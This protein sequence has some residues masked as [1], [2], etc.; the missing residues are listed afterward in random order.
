MHW[1]IHFRVNKTASSSTSTIK[2]HAET[3]REACMEVLNSYRAA[4]ILSYQ[5][6]DDPAEAF[7]PA[8]IGAACYPVDPNAFL[9]NKKIS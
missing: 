3:L 9:I 2:I 7:D 5:Q 4:T 6:N 8:K 1:K